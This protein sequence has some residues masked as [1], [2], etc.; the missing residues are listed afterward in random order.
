MGGGLGYAFYF[1]NVPDTL[2]HTWIGVWLWV[3]TLFWAGTTSVV[4]SVCTK[5]VDKY[6]EKRGKRKPP[7]K[8]K[9]VA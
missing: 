8:K 6:F 4:T 5:L 7:H 1:G 3:K 9:K 2:L